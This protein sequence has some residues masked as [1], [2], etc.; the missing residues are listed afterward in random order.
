M[1][2]ELFSEINS[3]FGY[4]RVVVFCNSLSKAHELCALLYDLRPTLFHLEMD[5][6]HRHQ[7]LESFTSNQV[8]MIFTIDSIKVNEFQLAD[9]VV[10]YDFPK[11]PICYLNTITEF[12]P[13]VN[14]FNFIQKHELKTKGIIETICK[15][16]MMLW[17]VK[18]TKYFTSVHI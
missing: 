9:C 16:S 7:I 17:P 8:G 11:N 1:K 13:R 6:N 4:G 18:V 10:Y 5:A 14:V 12:K 15:S 3:W 2:I